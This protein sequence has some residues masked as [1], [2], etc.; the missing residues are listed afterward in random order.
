[1]KGV[2]FKALFLLHETCHGDFSFI[3]PCIFLALSYSCQEMG[4][5]W[6]SRTALVSIE[7]N[8]QN[9]R[10]IITW[11]SLLQKDSAGNFVCS[12]YI[13]LKLSCLMN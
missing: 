3:D 6:A 12:F 9:K 10:C 8:S 5:F 13:C 1:M 7:I 2:I 11:T 4:A